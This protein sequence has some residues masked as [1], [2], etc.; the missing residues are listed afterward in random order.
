MAATPDRIVVRLDVHGA[1]EDIKR[2]FRSMVRTR[3][4]LPQPSLWRRLLLRLRRR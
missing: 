4:P 2:L 3:V 1:D